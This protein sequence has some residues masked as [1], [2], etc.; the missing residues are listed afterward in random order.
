M[1]LVLLVALLLAS[2]NSPVPRVTSTLVYSPPL[3]TSFEPSPP[4]SSVCS[5]KLSSASSVGAEPA[6]KIQLSRPFAKVVLRAMSVS[7]YP[8]S[9]SVRAGR[10][11]P[12][13]PCAAGCLSSGRTAGRGHRP[14]LT[15]SPAGH[16]RMPPP[17]LSRWPRVSY[18]ISH[19]TSPCAVL[20]CTRRC[21]P[22]P[23][24]SAHTAPNVRPGG[25]L[26]ASIAACRIAALIAIACRDGESSGTVACPSLL[27]AT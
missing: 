2:A 15:S 16:Q 22:T 20:P 14:T 26:A 3:P 8:L 21:N 5:E 4:G 19:C 11:W 9:V 25:A 1:A 17:T 24:S 23:S 12:T 18:G 6:R 10:C 27:S 13:F 7:P